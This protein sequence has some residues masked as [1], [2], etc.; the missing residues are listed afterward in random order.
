MDDDDRDAPRNDDDAIAAVLVHAWNGRAFGTVHLIVAT[1]DDIDGA[2]GAAALDA[3]ADANT[4]DDD[5]IADVAVAVDDDD[6]PIVAAFCARTSKRCVCIMILTRS[7][8]A[9]NV[10]AMAPAA[11]LDEGGEEEIGMD[12]ERRGE[13]GEERKEEREERGKYRKGR[14]E[15]E[16][17]EERE[18]ER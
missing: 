5:D 18:G 7:S 12:R 14:E 9:T 4:D 13:G 2:T 17:E 10:R 16:R 8:G 1:V 6:D 3:D 11:P 15:R